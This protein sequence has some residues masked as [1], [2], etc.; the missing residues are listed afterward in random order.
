MKAFRIG[1]AALLLL[2]LPGCWNSK[3]IQNMA[4]ITAIGLD[5]EGGKYT[6]YVQVLNF[7][8]VARVESMEV[9]K[10][11]PVWVGS[12]TGTSIAEA[13]GSL[14]ATSQLRIFWGHVKAIV[15]TERMMKMGMR[16][17]YNA[18]NRYREI[19]YNILVYGTKEKLTDILTQQSLLNLSPLDTIMFT[20]G[21]LY[22]QRSSILPIYGNQF[23]RQ[24]NE[25]GEA[26]ML[27]SIGIDR[28]H[29]REDKAG[30]AMFRITGAYFFDGAKMKTW[31]SEE[32][33]LGARWTQRKLVRTHVNVPNRG[34]PAATVVLI[35][36]RYSVN[37]VV[38]GKDVKFDVQVKVQG[39][40]DELLQD[41]AISRIEKETA[42]VVESELRATYGFGVDKGCDV[43]KLGEVLYRNDPRLFRELHRDGA[44]FLKRSSLRDIEVK[45]RLTNTGKYK[46]RTG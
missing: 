3:D 23:I 32:E 46:G 2:L 19:R 4:Y 1:F 18:I 30:R 41:A 6:A 35:K 43:L 33:L 45:V 15:C 7:N 17:A 22:S 13:L 29:W 10:E 16:E 20:P 8:N 44:F 24:V 37:P 14:N 31:M 38:Q 34:K 9:G 27:P 40:L 5:Y 11:I 36:P 39:Y 12:G 21:Q 28:G 26:A 42:A 25:P